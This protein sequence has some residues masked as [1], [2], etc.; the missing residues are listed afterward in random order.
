MRAQVTVVDTARASDC[1]RVEEALRR[2][3]VEADLARAHHREQ[4]R[5]HLGEALPWVVTVAL[6]TPIA[7]FFASIASEAG[8]DAWVLIKRWA[9]ELTDVR[10]PHGY[11]DIELRDP[12]GTSVDLRPAAMN[13]EEFAGLLE[14]DWTE[15]RGGRL[16]WSSRQGK[17]VQAD[18]VISE[19]RQDLEDG[20]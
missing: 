10:P 20:T 15:M 8:K 19:L 12:E 13:D 11:G 17:W 16:A 1:A 4:D 14:I 9:R 2:V 5:E 7:A 18:E 6:A 3:G